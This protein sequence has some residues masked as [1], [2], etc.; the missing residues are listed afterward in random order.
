MKTG[1]RGDLV[2]LPGL[3][4]KTDILRSSDHTLNFT[5]GSNSA[6]MLGDSQTPKQAGHVRL[7][8]MRG[9]IAVG[10]DGVD[11]DILKVQKR[12]SVTGF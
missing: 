6:A 4:G 3:E 12:L 7:G 10:F 9:G 1:S 2:Q 5:V 8:S 11:N